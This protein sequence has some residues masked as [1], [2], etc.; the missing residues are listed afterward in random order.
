MLFAERGHVASGCVDGSARVWD[1]ATGVLLVSLERTRG[2]LWSLKSLRV[3]CDDRTTV[4]VLA[5]ASR[6]ACARIYVPTVRLLV[7]PRTRIHNLPSIHSACSRSDLASGDACLP[8]S[9][10]RTV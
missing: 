3:M 6:D 8:T 4:T 1:A 10:A 2:S 5:A 9:G 7:A